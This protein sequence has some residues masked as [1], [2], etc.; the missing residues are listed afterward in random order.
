MIERLQRALERVEELSPE[1]QEEIAVLI[2][3]QTEPIEPIPASLQSP[4]RPGEEHLPQRVRD[5]LAAIG[6]WRDLPDSFD[7]M[8]DALDRIRHESKP[9][10]PMDEQLAW[11]SDAKIGDEAE[12]DYPV[13]E[14][15]EKVR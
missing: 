11:L 7:E 2:E 6:S 14:V 8:L 13:Q 12:N 15:P 4:L 3:E 9:S 5:A 10:P 1:E